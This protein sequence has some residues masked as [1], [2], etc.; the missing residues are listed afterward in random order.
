MTEAPSV[1]D[2]SDERHMRM[3]VQNC[4]TPHRRGYHTRLGA[5]MWTFG[6]G[7]TYAAQLIRRFGF[8]P[9]EMVR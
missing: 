3:A 8:D 5:V 9:D 6:L 7:S 1:N 4:R 2:I